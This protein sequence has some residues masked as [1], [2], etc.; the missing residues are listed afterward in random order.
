VVWSVKGHHAHALRRSPCPGHR[1]GR[2]LAFTGVGTATLSAPPLE[3]LAAA[4]LLAAREPDSAWRRE[5][6]PEQLPPDGDWFIWLVCAGRGWG[7]TWSGAHW[8]AEQ[9]IENVGDYAVVGRSEPDVRQTCLEGRSGL[10]AALGLTRDSPQYRRGTGQIRLDNGS[11]IY[12][13]SAES[14]EQ[15]RGPNFSGAWLDELGAWRFAETVWSETLVPA[16]RIGRDPKIT[17]T[18]TPRPTK[19]LRELLSRKDG[20]VVVTH[21]TTFQNRAHLSASAL[22]ELQRRYEGT[23]IAIRSP[24]TGSMLAGVR[25]PSSKELP[26]VS[27]C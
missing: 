26:R 8:L 16:V 1:P 20:S 21:G 10:L 5:A 15:L 2:R 22:G 7:K 25:R 14:P 27:R 6:R 12:A 4:D 23:R 9:A 3:F 13:Y 19:L 17:I 24:S 18:N 11:V